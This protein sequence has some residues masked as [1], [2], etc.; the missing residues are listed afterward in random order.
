MNQINLLIWAE[1][2]ESWRSLCTAWGQ[3][4]D[5]IIFIT[6][7]Q[8]GAWV[9]VCAC[10]FMLAY[11]NPERLRVGGGG[12]GL[13]EI[14]SPVAAKIL[15]WCWKTCGK[16][17]KKALLSLNVYTQEASI[18][19]VWQKYRVYRLPV[20]NHPS[21]VKTWRFPPNHRLLLHVAVSRWDFST[22]YVVVRECSH[23]NCTNL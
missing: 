18:F 19:L 12:R 13:F 8:Y 3:D 10:R 22:F 6:H 21:H 15:L 2:S 5:T 17:W 16:I 4:K 9:K 7:A 20:I 23:R 1:F 11:I 14:Y